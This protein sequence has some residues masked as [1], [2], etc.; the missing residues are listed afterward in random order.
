MLFVFALKFGSVYVF[1]ASVTE[2]NWHSQKKNETVDDCHCATFYTHE[3][4]IVIL[5]SCT[6]DKTNKETVMNTDILKNKIKQWNN[7]T[8]LDKKA[9]ISLTKWL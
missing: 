9:L 2:I 1:M 5:F 6:R 4:G 7:T 3:S 8:Q